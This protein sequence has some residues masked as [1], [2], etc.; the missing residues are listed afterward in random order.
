MLALAGALSFA[1]GLAFAGRAQ[2]QT[3]SVNVGILKM[4]ALTNPWVAQKEGI[5]K[6]NGIDVKLTEF[7]TGNEA[8]AAL[9]GGSVDIVLAIPGTAMTAIE[10]GFDLVA[11]GQNE[12]ARTQGPDSGSLQVLKDSPIKS[13][14]DLAGKKVAVSSLHS[15]NTV[16]V[17]KLIKD[18]GVNLKSVQFLELPF[19]AQVDA[20]RTKQVDAVATVDPYTTQLQAMGL[21]RVI[22]WNYVESLPEQPLGAW[23]AKNAYVK[24][25]PA[26]IDGFAS[27]I[28]ESIE[29]MN[30]DPERARAAVVSF[31]G[32]DPALVKDMPLIKWD[33]QIKMDRWQKVIDMMKDAGDLQKEHKAESFI[34]DRMKPYIAN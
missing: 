26:I 6:K 10:R 34:S 12:I 24:R 22:S 9:Q 27:S 11:I 1:S 18:A 28:R 2:A 14:A 25:N 5:F 8:I 19:P 29:Y 33:Y 7:R 13:L 17:Q 23:F 20:L 3:P 30:A 16:G 21:G 32:L 15:Q 31:T 4:A